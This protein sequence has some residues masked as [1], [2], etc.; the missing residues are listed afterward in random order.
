MLHCTLVTYVLQGNIMD[1][2]TLLAIIN[3]RHHTT[4]APVER[5]HSG[6]QGAFALIDVSGQRAVLKWSHDTHYL[7]TQQGVAQTTEALRHTGYPTP[8]YLFTGI[9]EN[10]TYIVQE[11]L[12]GT[13]LHILTPQYLPSVLALNE[14]QLGHAVLS[15]HEWPARV[16]DTV[17]YGGDGYC[18]I[19]T[20]RTYSATTR[21]LLNVL[22]TI[23]NTHRDAE[24]RT[25]DIVHYDFHCEN[26]LT[27]YSHI[28]GVIDWDGTCSGDAGFDLVTLLCYA[29]MQ[30]DETV[31]A[32][33]WQHALERSGR[34]AVSVYVAH[35][36]VRQIDWMIRFRQQ[37]DVNSWL[38]VAE[39]LVGA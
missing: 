11:M 32:R 18:V 19:E 29:Y 27:S 37:N 24:Y 17:L 5:Y 36:L 22:Q 4:F 7:V 14:M 34:A 3:E 21:E 1:V 6:E 30:S 38:H 39:E 28:S 35:M 10:N 20:L 8:R 15:Q 9:V 12:P 26:I 31:K 2:N 16:I 33:L 23:V 13:P 25:G